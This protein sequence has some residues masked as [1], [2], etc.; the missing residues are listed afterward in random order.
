[1]SSRGWRFPP[2]AW[3]IRSLEDIPAGDDGTLWRT[4]P[5][6]Q[7]LVREGSQDP[8]V[9]AHA[10]RIASSNPGL[11]PAEAI[12][13]HVQRMPYRYDEQIARSNGLGDPDVS[14][15]LQGASYQVKKE[16]AHG[17]ESVEGDCDCRSIYV[18]SAL[19]SLGYPTRFAIVKGP[20]RQNYGHVYS[21]VKVEDGRWL[22]LDTIMDG[23]DGRPFFKAGQELLPPEGNDKLTIPT[24][25]TSWV[26][27]A[28]AGAL[29]W[30]LLKG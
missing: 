30:R 9:R 8:L 4:I 16:L 29:A 19:E 13:N 22:P 3:P 21:E 5:W 27:F 18:Q 12:F 23:N 6:M 10:S 17:S 25:K 15:I 11:H 1:M 24:K 2:I 14:E 28:V 26:G 7:R 20:A